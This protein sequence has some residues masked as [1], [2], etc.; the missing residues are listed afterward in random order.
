MQF[1]K[2]TNVT[3]QPT[4]YMEPTQAPV[5]NV[6]TTPTRRLNFNRPSSGGPA[7]Q[8][9]STQA[10]AAPQPSAPAQ[11]QYRNF[12]QPTGNQSVGNAP[13]ST[14]NMWSDTNKILKKFVNKPKN[15]PKGSAVEFSKAAFN[16]GK[17]DG[18][19]RYESLEGK[20]LMNFWTFD[21]Q[22]NH[23]LDLIPTYMDLSE[24]LNVCHLITSNRL[25]ELTAQARQQQQQTGSR[26]CRWIYQNNGGSHKPIYKVN[27][28]P[29]G[30]D[31]PKA[32]SFKIIPG[33]RDNTWVLSSELY[34]GQTSGTGLIEIKPGSAPVLRIQN[35]FSYDDLV[36]IAE[37]SKAAIYAR[38]A[39]LATA[40]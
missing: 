1:R 6:Q 37:M 11:P 5:E 39:A 15:S 14:G 40:Q 31:G 3:E 26:Y 8:G 20:M 2:P 38:M 18:A 16:L 17:K 32:V 7:V 33:M 29:Y 21:I 25:Q 13:V 35:I 22:T 9:T 28:K 10:P 4:L 19:N 27:G 30:G 24:W 36:S 23:Q 34:D 12:S